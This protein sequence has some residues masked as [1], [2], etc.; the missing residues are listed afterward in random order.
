MVLRLLHR[1]SCPEVDAVRVLGV[2]DW[3]LRKGERYGT[4]LV[5]L[6]RHRTVDLL[7]ER[8]AESLAKWLKEH[9]G[10]E[11]LTRDRGE[12]YAEGARV[13][14]PQAMQVADRFHLCKNLMEAIEKEVAGQLP[15][16]RRL[17]LHQEPS[18]EGP[19]QVELNRR[20]QREREESRAQRL[21]LWQQ[22]QELGSQGYTR[23]EI[24]Q[25][26]GLEAHTVCRYLRSSTFPERHQR[27]P[28][29]SRLDPYKP[30]L[31]QRWQE[32]CQNASQLWRELQEQGFV[33][34]ATAVRD[35]VHP[36]R[37]MGEAEGPHQVLTVKV[38]AVRA[39]AWLLV[40]PD[41][42]EPER[43]S[44]IEDLC[45]GCPPLGQVRQLAEG[46]FALV[47]GQAE[48]DLS[49]WQ[50]RVENSGLKHL[51]ALAR[52]LDRDRA[53]VDAALREPWSNGPTEGHVNRL[54]L[55]KRQ[56]YGRASFELL[57]RR[58]LLAP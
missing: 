38:P 6:E 33:G 25:R 52:G 2:D 48:S 35:C 30:Y 1:L 45:A 37:A 24:G 56:M 39:L 12:A 10:V 41:P 27:S 42:E 21:A 5:D 14:A 36:W 11:I 58:V 43:A 22:V 9:P 55:I 23:K 57:R 4:I 13:G 3:A 29:G 53:A 50:A 18:P 8:S 31:L 34:G 17:L 15:A 51:G 7:P 26:C 49:T 16:I 28:S 46:F 44:M 54:K 20:R 32:G 40:R 19:G 47:H